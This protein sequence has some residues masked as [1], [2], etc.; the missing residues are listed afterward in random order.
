MLSQSDL[1]SMAA[2]RAEGWGLPGRFYTDPEVYEA[3]IEMV[4]RRQ[5]LFAGHDC[6]IP[7][8]GDYL[9]LPLHNDSLL[10]IRGDDGVVRAMHN[11][12]RHRG[13]LLC[14]EESGHAAK[15]VC[16]YHQWVYGRDGTL[17][18]ARGMPSD[19]DKGRFGLT[20]IPTRTVEGLI[21]ICLAEDPPDFNPAAETLEAVARPQGLPRA[22]AAQIIDYEVAANWKIVWENNRECYHCNANHPQYIR[23]NFDH[24]NDDDTSE[25][26]AAELASAVGRAQAKWRAA[27]LAATHRQTGM[28]CF[29]DPD[30][31]IWY[32]ANRTVLVNGYLSESMDGR[33]V[34]T[35]MGDYTDP[36]VGTVRMR[37]MPN[38]WIHA[39]CD[40]VVSTRLLPAGLEHT[41]VR[42]AWL[43]DETAVEGKDYQ[44]D[45]LLP[46]WR[47]TSEQD[48]ELCA[49]AQR[50]VRSSGY[51]P[52][53]FSRHKEYNVDA[54]V[55]W[56][57]KS[58]T[59]LR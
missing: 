29:P 23:A 15:L 51:Q 18:S 49:A 2:A 22:K 36:D 27:G 48:W 54:F 37:T 33:L 58:L 40:H 31:D 57:L 45:H 21:Y 39:S 59:G 44:L 56:Y 25:A 6:Q 16:P 24:Y 34:S 11:V 13:A 14:R 32:S 43:V 17:L 52:G 5:W 46:F 53:P 4:W 42:V 41:L 50:G 26:V 20:R 7:A 47:L 1:E 8:K 10:I 28:T 35:L 55:R 12:C 3:E 38:M 30:R 19:L 9:V